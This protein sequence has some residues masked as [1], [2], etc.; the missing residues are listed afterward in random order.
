MGEGI[1]FDRATGAEAGPPRIADDSPGATPVHQ[2]GPGAGQERMN[3]PL[4][5]REIRLRGLPQRKW[6]EVQRGGLSSG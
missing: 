1:N 6:A 5:T 3:P 4:E 2:G